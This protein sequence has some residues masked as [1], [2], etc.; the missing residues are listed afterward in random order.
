MWSTPRYAPEELAS[1]RRGLRCAAVLALGLVGVA[2]CQPQKTTCGALCT[3]AD[4]DAASCYEQAVRDGYATGVIVE[5]TAS[6]VG[7]ECQG[8]AIRSGA[9][10]LTFA[11]LQP[12]GSVAVTFADPTGNEAPFA[13]TF[14]EPDASGQFQFYVEHTVEAADDPAD[15]TSFVY[16]IAGMVAGTGG[17]FRVDAKL[18]VTIFHR[19]DTKNTCVLTAELQ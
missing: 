11:A 18:T 10:R 19:Q 3:A 2:A 1:P 17:V 13:G 12:D 4:G 16:S 9:C 7:G 15:P 14:C 8:L 6:S 5:A